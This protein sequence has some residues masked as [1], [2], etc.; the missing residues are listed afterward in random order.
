MNTIWPIQNSDN[1]LYT[2][3]LPN[4]DFNMIMFMTIKTIKKINSKQ[5]F[6]VTDQVFNIILY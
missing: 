1:I 6:F 5:Y 3:I 4:I 2:H